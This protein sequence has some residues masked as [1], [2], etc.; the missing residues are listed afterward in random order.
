MAL[1]ILQIIYGA[2]IVIAGLILAVAGGAA[3]AFIGRQF[4]QYGGETWGSL[5]A[6]MFIIV[7]IMI[8][9]FGALPIVSGSGLIRYQNWG[10]IFT[11]IMATLAG[12]SAIP[13]LLEGEIVGA[14]IP[15]G[16]ATYAW[17]ILTRPHVVALFHNGQQQQ[18]TIVIESS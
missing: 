8:A 4:S 2:V 1:A 11:L 7:G 14:L 13:S 3:S 15:G 12:L 5:G 16:F 9:A 6:V 10:R 18:Q 17:I